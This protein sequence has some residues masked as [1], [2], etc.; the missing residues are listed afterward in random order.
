MFVQPDQGGGLD[1]RGRRGPEQSGRRAV[2][3][4]EVAGG[5][6]GLLQLLFLTLGQFEIC[7]DFTDDPNSAFAG[8]NFTFNY[9]GVEFP[10]VKGTVTV[11]V[12]ACSQP[13]VVPAGSVQPETEYSRARWR[14]PVPVP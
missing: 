14:S 7:K 3:A 12:D 2:E 13:I 10:K 9:Q 5:D 4:E 6:P 11:A 8:T 1:P